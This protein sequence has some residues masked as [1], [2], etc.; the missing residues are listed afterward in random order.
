M[1]FSR[2][3]L[4]FFMGEHSNV[5]SSENQ[6][7][8]LNNT[9]YFYDLLFCFQFNSIQYTCMLF[10]I[11]YLARTKWKWSLVFIW[12]FFLFKLMKLEIAKISDICDNNNNN[13]NKPHNHNRNNNNLNLSATDNNI[14]IYNN[15]S[16]KN[17]MIFSVFVNKMLKY[18]ISNI[19]SPYPCFDV[20]FV[21]VSSMWDE[22][23]WNIYR[24]SP[25]V[26]YTNTHTHTQSG[27]KIAPA[28]VV[29]FSRR[30][31][32]VTPSHWHWVCGLRANIFFSVFFLGLNSKWKIEILYGCGSVWKFTLNRREEKNVETKNICTLYVRTYY[33]R[34]TLIY[35]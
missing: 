1:N 6:M 14:P 25:L 17:I 23:L 9:A 5:C 22:L 33:Y 26:Y 24:V 30:F 32:C 11:Q 21:P 13:N 29:F 2:K 4:R 31:A 10:P 19:W 34:I 28:I 12:Y 8:S 20:L 16:N 35:S 18:Q 15:N 27:Q 7:V 3:C